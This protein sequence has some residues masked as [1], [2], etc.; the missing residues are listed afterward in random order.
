MASITL[1]PGRWHGS[2]SWNMERSRAGWVRAAN[3]AQKIRDR[4]AAIPGVS[5]ADAPDGHQNPEPARR[6]VSMTSRDVWSVD[7][8]VDVRLAINSGQ[9]DSAATLALR[10]AGA[11]RDWDTIRVAAAMAACGAPLLGGDTNARGAGVLATRSVLGLF[12][13]FG[14]EY[15]FGTVCSSFET[16]GGTPPAPATID[17]AVGRLAAGP[18]TDSNNRDRIGQSDPVFVI[19]GLDLGV[20]PLAVKITLISV[21]SLAGL[22]VVGYSARGVAGLI[23]EVK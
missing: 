10:D 16:Y 17:G 5:F 4:F 11:G 8:W 6:S 15:T 2:F 7:V 18:I 14:P 22:I 19:P 13:A 12:A 20:S 21:A 3:L 9:L 23:R 1:A